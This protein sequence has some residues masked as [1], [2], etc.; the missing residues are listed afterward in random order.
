MPA[1]NADPAMRRRK[2]WTTETAWRVRVK[3]PL[4]PRWAKEGPKNQANFGHYACNGSHG[5]K[6]SKG[7]SGAPRDGFVKPTPY[8]EDPT[9][10]SGETG[11]YGQ[12]FFPEYNVSDWGNKVRAQSRHG[13][14]GP[15]VE[16]DAHR[17]GRGPGQG[18]LN[19]VAQLSGPR[20]R[21]TRITTSR[22]TRV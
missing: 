9:S 17:Q 4:V 3:S 2:D 15:I 5:L 21:T 1:G 19:Y 7:F 18:G 6:Q 14:A 10:G 8:D 11:F 13:D 16:G 20:P 22:N 12:P